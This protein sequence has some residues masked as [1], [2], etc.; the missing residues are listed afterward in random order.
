LLRKELAELAVSRAWW[1]LLL[2]IGLLTGQ[3]FAQAVRSYAEMSAPG[4][5]AQGLSPLD[6]LVVPVLGAYELAMML[7]FPFVAI[8]LL[9]QERETG[10][11]KLMLQWRVRRSTLIASKVATLLVAWIVSLIPF[12]LALLLWRMSG[13]HLDVREVANVLAGYSLRFLLTVSLAMLAAALLPGAANA[14]VAVL[15]FTIGTWALDFLGAGRGGLIQALAA[16]TPAAV[17]RSFERGLFR[18]DL[19]LV[20]VILSVTALALTSIWI[21]AGAPF[22]SRVQRALI[23]LM[24]AGALALAAS[25]IPYSLDAS[26]NR[27]NSFSPSE[28]RTLG[29]IRQSLTLTV[30]LSAEDPRLADL[31]TNVLTKLRRAMRVNVRYP[32]AG[33]TALFDDDDRYGTIEYSLGEKHATNRSTT[34]AIV[35]ETIC[36]LAGVPAPAAEESSYP[37]YPLRA[38]PRGTWLFYVAWPVVIAVLA[39]RKLYA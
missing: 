12:A 4:V 28:T 10:A 24:I 30:W 13:G 36:E 37:G 26:E 39:W 3:A 22:R 25:R 17:T 29:S 34:E 32:L 18:L 6:G 15:A 8:R 16:Y 11:L 27:R 38:A 2:A 20:L 33:R 35:V 14:A 5:L 31:E 1:L 7:L 19:A 21:D 23:A 9:A